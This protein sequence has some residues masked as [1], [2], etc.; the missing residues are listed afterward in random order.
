M[1]VI[2]NDAFTQYT[3]TGSKTFF[4]FGFPVLEGG[5]VVV[6][7]DGLPVAFTLQATG[8]VIEPAPALNAFIEIFRITNVDQ[9]SNWEEFESFDAAKTEDAVDKQIRLKQEGF[10]AGMNLFADPKLDRVILVNDKGDD[11]HILIWNEL[12]GELG[13]INDAGVF[14]GLVTTMMPCPGAVVEKPDHFAYFQY[15]AAQEQQILTTTLYPIEVV[16]GM[17]LSISLVDGQMNVIPEEEVEFGFAALDGNI[18]P[19]LISTGPHDEAVEFAFA[20]LDGNITSKLVS[21]L[22]PEEGMD[23]SIALVAGSMTPV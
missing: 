13:V 8:V 16:E 20:A 3:G 18:T 7:V 17:D 5:T 15:G 4:E 10:R 9:L 6:F 22:M 19:I 23:I 2:F 12:A 1:A 14:A 21:A 11:A